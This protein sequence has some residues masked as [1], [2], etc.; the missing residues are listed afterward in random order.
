MSIFRISGLSGV[1]FRA[2]QYNRTNIMCTFVERDLFEGI[3][4][5]ECRGWQIQNLQGR[6]P[7]RRPGGLGELLWSAVQSHPGGKI[8]SFS[9]DFSLSS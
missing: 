5:P 2:L 9:E 4:L 8:S 6:S 3:G 7:S 1:F